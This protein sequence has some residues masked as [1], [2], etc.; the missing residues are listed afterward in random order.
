MSLAAAGVSA[1]VMLIVL[2]LWDV[3]TA[4]GLN[5]N[6]P[7]AVISLAGAGTIF[8]ILYWF[9]DKHAWRWAPVGGWLKAPDLSGVWS[10]HGTSLKPDG[11]VDRDWTGTVTIVQSWERIRVR[12][13]TDHSGSNSIA[14]AL[15]CDEADGFRLLYNYRND[16][17]AGQPDLQSHRGFAELVFSHDR[18]SA[19]GEYFNG[20]GRFTFGK[21]RL[22]K[23]SA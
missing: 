2:T 22:T 10:C 21:M 7:P 20:Q 9:L 4:F 14:A 16:P 15:V 13:K 1:V 12:M 6:I 5:A 17:K 23:E 11:S 19:E 8:T 3:A 18:A